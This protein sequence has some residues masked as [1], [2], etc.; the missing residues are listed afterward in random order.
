VRGRALGVFRD[1][2]PADGGNAF[3]GIAAA[4][5]SGVGR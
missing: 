3:L 4:E 2:V 5:Y 1:G